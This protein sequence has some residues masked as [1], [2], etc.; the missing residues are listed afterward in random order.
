MSSAAE[1]PSSTLVLTGAESS[2]FMAKM[3]VRPLGWVVVVIGLSIVQSFRLGMSR[4]YL[5]L[6]SAAFLSAI[7][8]VGYG[9]LI[10]VKPGTKSWWLVLVNYSLLIPYLLGCYLVFVRGF[11]RLSELT[12]GFSIIVL[13]KAGAFVIVGYFLVSGLSKLTDAVRAV[14][15]GHIVVKADAD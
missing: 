15:E 14:G 7:T 5:M 13:L 3:I 9:F 11:W 4:G 6:G 10:F 12:T 8:I 2:D 1:K